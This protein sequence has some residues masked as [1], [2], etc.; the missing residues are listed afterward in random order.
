MQQ[1]HFTSICVML[2]NIQNIQHRNSLRKE[3]AVDFEK[4]IME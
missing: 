2:N 3:G 1:K 4:T